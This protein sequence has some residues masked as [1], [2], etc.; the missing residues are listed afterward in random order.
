MRKDETEVRNK[1]T[2][3]WGRTEDPVLFLILE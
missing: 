1:G 3:I 2:T